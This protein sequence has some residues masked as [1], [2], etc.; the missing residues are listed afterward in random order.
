MID[1]HNHLQ[2]SLLQPYLREILKNC[3]ELGI[4]HQV[5]NGTSERDWEQVY[6][7][8]QK[9]SGSIIP[10]YGLHP[11]YIDSRTPSWID[12]L[13]QYLKRDSSWIGEIGIDFCKSN[14][15]QTDQ[16]RIFIQ[17]LE[18]AHTYKRP[19]SIHCIQSWGRLLQLL[20]DNRKWL[21]T[22]VLHSYG[23]SKEM[24]PQFSDLGGFFSYSATV[25][26]HKRKKQ[27]EALVNTPLE[28]L[29]LETDAPNQLPT[30]TTQNFSTKKGLNTPC[31]IEALYSH[32]ASL[33]KIPRSQLILQCQTNLTNCI[34]EAAL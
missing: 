11:W 22:F 6:Q 23:G 4:S 1:I 24:I 14:A 3:K 34:E 13:D 30:E 33:R 17:Q 7:L 19:V 26:N 18:L 16:E 28:R 8:S 15:T 10:S 25:T 5:V 12:L 2:S 20:Q 9:F 29:F 27:Q 32:T 21:T 31:T